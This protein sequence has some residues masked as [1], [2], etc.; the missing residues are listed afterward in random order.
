MA[1][2]TYR[3]AVSLSIA[4]CMRKDEKVV[5]L[6][7]RKFKNGYFI[8]TGWALGGNEKVKIPLDSTIWKVKGNNVLTPNNP[9]VL[10][11]DNNE[12]VSYTHLTLPTKA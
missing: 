1:Q 4:Q 10:E 6:N 3:E 9:I 2:L 7:P 8:E 11:W 5:F 12:A